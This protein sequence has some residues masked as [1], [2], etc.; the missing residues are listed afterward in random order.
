MAKYKFRLA[1]LL[2][3]RE[4]ERDERR[5]ELAEA[6]RAADVLRSQRASLEDEL[7]SLRAARAPGTGVLNVDLM[8][9]ASQHE[10]LLRAQADLLDKQSAEVQVEAERRRARL[11]E[12]DRAVKVLEKLRDRQSQRF[13]EEQL[14]HE[15]KT[16]DDLGQRLAAGRNL[17][18]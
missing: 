3:L 5:G 14:R 15:A 13:T 11:M 16:L 9:R 1:T 8:I 10:L 4:S 2:K 17:E 12:A 6:L 7:R 18:P